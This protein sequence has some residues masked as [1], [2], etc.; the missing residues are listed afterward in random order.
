MSDLCY[1]IVFLLWRE[2]MK[3][4]Y[5]HQPDQRL[6]IWPLIGLSLQ[7]DDALEGKI[8]GFCEKHAAPQQYP[9]ALRRSKGKTCVNFIKRRDVVHGVVAPS[10]LYK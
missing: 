7:R 6:K 2:H 4:I 9:K 10:R 5:H 8:L 3:S 1:L